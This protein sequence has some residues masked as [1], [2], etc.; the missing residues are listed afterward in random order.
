[1]IYPVKNPRITSP[2]GMRTITDNKGVTTKFHSGV[3]FAPVVKGEIGDDIISVLD[4]EVVRLG[5]DENGYGKYI[6][7]QHSNCCTLYAHLVFKGVK[8]AV[9][10]K[11]KQGQVIAMMGNTGHCVGGGR[12]PGAHLHF[13]VRDIDFDQR[14]FTNE[15]DGRKYKAIDPIKAIIGEEVKTMEKTKYEIEIDEA[16]EYVIKNGISD[17]TDGKKEMTREQLWVMLYRLSKLK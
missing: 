10:D 5:Y 9:G 7:I 3:D 13:E 11:V 15:R 6:V 8:V 4:G 12:Y 16:R 2:F 1:M 14:F 17:G